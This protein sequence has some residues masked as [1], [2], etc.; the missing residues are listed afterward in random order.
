MKLVLVMKMKQIGIW[1]IQESN[2][3]QDFI[4]IAGEGFSVDS[5]DT[6]IRIEK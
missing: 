2:Y 1:I 5:S 3:I 4:E 6:M